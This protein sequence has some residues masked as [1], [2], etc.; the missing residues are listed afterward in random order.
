MYLSFSLSL[1]VAN[2]S[3]F[4]SL[5]DD[6]V[7][8]LRKRCYDLAGTTGLR[9]F[10]NGERL[11]IKNFLQYVG[12]YFEEAEGAASA[13]SKRRTKQRRGGEDGG[14]EDSSSDFGEAEVED[15]EGDAE[16][17]ASEAQQ[18]GGPVRKVVKIHEKQRRWEVVISQ[19]GKLLVWQSF[20]SLFHSRGNLS[21]LRV[22]V[23][24]VRMRRE[25]HFSASVFRELH[26]HNPR[27]PSRF[28]RGGPSAAGNSKEG[29]RE[30]PRRNGGEAS[31]RQVR[32]LTPLT[33]VSRLSVECLR[34]QSGLLPPR[35]LLRADTT[36]LYL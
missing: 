30:E 11:P 8:L 32:F 25:R 3:C 29:E 10:L 9:I 5:D 20:L 24:T 2:V 7:A 13:G 12:L 27:R 31:A 6:S 17:E 34:R 14:G 28:P 15:R 36:C 35:L 26:L 18:G 19:S 4:S 1:S 23:G 21:V 33:R 16:R 22:L